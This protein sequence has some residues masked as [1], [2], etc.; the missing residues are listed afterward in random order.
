MSKFNNTKLS[1]FCQAKRLNVKAFLGVMVLASLSASNVLAYDINVDTTAEVDNTMCTVKNAVHLANTPAGSFGA[2]VLDMSDANPAVIKIN[3]GMNQTYSIMTGEASGFGPAALPPITTATPIIINGNG[4][5]IMRAVGAM[6]EFRIIA[7]D[8][9]PFQ[10]FTLNQVTLTNGVASGNVAAGGALFAFGANVTLNQSSI[11]GNMAASSGGGIHLQD[12]SLTVNS[13]TISNNTSNGSGGGLF[14]SIP[15]IS[16]GQAKITNSTISNNNGGGMFY[17]CSDVRVS[18]DLDISYTT[19][20][21]NTGGLASGLVISVFV[22]SSNAPGGDINISHTIIANYNNSPDCFLLAPPGGFNSFSTDHSINGDNSCN[23]I[24]TGDKVNIAQTGVG[25]LNIGP[26]QDNGGPTFTHQLLT[27]PDA[28]VAINMGADGAAGCPFPGGTTNVDQR[29]M[30]RPGVGNTLCD[31]GAYEFGAPNIVISPLPLEL[32]PVLV[33]G[34]MD[35]GVFNI[36]NDGNEPLVISSV[37]LQ[38]LDAQFSLDLPMLV[39]PVVIQPGASA[40]QVGV[41]FTAGATP[42]IFTDNLLVS[43][44]DPDGQ[45]S[46]QVN[47][48]AESSSGPPDIQEIIDFCEQCVADGNLMG[49]LPKRHGHHNYQWG[50]NYHSSYGNHGDWIK[51]KVADVRLKVWKSKLHRVGKLLSRGKDHNA[52]KLLNHLILRADGE[53]KP[54]D[55]VKGACLTDDQQFNPTLLQQLKDLRDD[56]CNR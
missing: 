25:G 4:S 31:I 45:A 56:V 26:L 10:D 17:L 29:G 20:V 50:H 42:G 2:C 35:P 8:P 1:E 30:Q 15:I 28:S 23:F 44:N 14:V 46:A 24:G 27:V 51:M 5:T 38:G 49:V 13:S 32:G 47:G 37:A 54:K 11:V 21:G 19:I 36:N 33:N 53:V 16:G 6:T 52:C 34:G 7:L 12:S 48:E 18:C 9:V 40:S 43:S 3:L 55:F 39:P 41:K 22:E